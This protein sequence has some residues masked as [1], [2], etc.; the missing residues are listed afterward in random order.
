M[1]NRRQEKVLREIEPEGSFKLEGQG[2][3]ALGKCKL[4]N[5]EVANR[6]DRSCRSRIH[7]WNSRFIYEEDEMKSHQDQRQSTIFDR[8]RQT[9]EKQEGLLKICEV[10]S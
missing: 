10:R 4:C 7:E 5:T 8:G 1:L 3:L 6:T 9:C 2:M